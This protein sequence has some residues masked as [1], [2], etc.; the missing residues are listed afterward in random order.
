MTWFRPEMGPPGPKTTLDEKIR[1]LASASPLIV[2][3]LVSIGGIYLGVFTPVEAAGIGAFLISGMALAGG[4]MKPGDFVPVLVD[5]ARTTAM[6]FFI[7]IGASVFGPFLALTHIP[8]SLA[9]GLATLDLGRYGVLCAILATYI[10]LGTFLESFAML[11]ITTPIVF[12]IITGLGFDPIWFGVLVVIVVEMGLITPPVGLN[13]FVVKGVA[14]DVPMGI[15]FA[16]VLPFWIAMLL[17]LALLV[18]FPAISLYLPSTMF[19]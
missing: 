15:I 14:A 17:C 8:E 12:P 1:V 5:S 2:V 6:L 13:V 10:V 4:F 19:N 3:I 7:V 11:V 9:Q 18:I 16:G